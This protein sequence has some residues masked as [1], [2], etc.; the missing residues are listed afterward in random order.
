[1]GVNDRDSHFDGEIGNV[2]P[3]SRYHRR[4]YPEYYDIDSVRHWY[5]RWKSAEQVMRLWEERERIRAWY[6]SESGYTSSQDPHATTVITVHVTPLR[7]ETAKVCLAHHC[8]WIARDL[9]AEHG[10]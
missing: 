5:G 7:A 2:E 1:M 3:W 10:W 8:F 9:R 4:L 6:E